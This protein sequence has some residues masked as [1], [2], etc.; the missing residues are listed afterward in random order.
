[1]VQP[2]LAKAEEPMYSCGECNQPVFLVA[3]DEEHEPVLI[4]GIVYKPCGHTNAKVLA[5]MSALVRGTSEVK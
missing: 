1:M 5:N 4:D 2:N 3:H